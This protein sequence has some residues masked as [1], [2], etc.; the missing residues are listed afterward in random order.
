MLLSNSTIFIAF[1][2]TYMLYLK[3]QLVYYK[4]SSGREPVKD[5]LYELKEDERIEIRQLFRL[6]LEKEGRLVPPQAKHIFKKIW[7]LRIQYLNRYHR[8]FYFIGPNR[9]IVLLSAFQKKSKKTPRSEIQKAHNY[10][11]DYLNAL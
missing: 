5:Y 7:E 1:N 2:I 10:Y 3:Y 9:K 8:I 11:I 4:R 6:L